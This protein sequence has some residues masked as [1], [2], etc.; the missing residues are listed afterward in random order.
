ME[1]ETNIPPVHR[2]PQH[3]PQ[4]YLGILLKRRWAFLAVFIGIVALCAIYSF[5]A[6]PYY[7]ATVQLLIERQAP[8]LLAQEPGSTE[9][10][11]NE[12]FY[13]TQYKLLE[14]HALAKKVIDQLQ[15]QNNPAYATI[16]RGL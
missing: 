15:L 14:S 1:S 7:K 16:F 8:R 11:V 13:Q 9:Y 2:R 10:G 6:T 3:S 5:T 12:E 4:E